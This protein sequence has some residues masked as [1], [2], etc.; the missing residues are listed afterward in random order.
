MPGSPPQ[1]RLRSPPFSSA[2]RKRSCG[3]RRLR[4]GR[5]ARRVRSEERRDGRA[6]HGSSPRKVIGPEPRAGTASRARCCGPVGGRGLPEP[7]GIGA[8]RRPRGRPGRSGLPLGSSATTDRRRIPPRE[9]PPRRESRGHCRAP[10]RGGPELRTPH[11]G[12][13]VTRPARR[14]DPAK[15]RHRTAPH[16]AAPRCAAPTAGIH[17]A[18]AMVCPAL[19]RPRNVRNHRRSGTGAER[20][21]A[22]APPPGGGRCRASRCADGSA[23]R[24]AAGSALP[25]SVPA[26]WGGLRQRSVPGSEQ[27]YAAGVCVTAAVRVT[28]GQCPRD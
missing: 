1:P 19:L 27:R 11:R 3:H 22:T 18:A 14:P 7:P 8:S 15:E 23:P 26:L 12:A 13:K 6:A 17:A 20:P 5:T 16:R 4:A 2:H 21:R 25:S 28:D 24:C 10:L 9:A